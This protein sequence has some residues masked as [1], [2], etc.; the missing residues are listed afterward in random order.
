MLF[1]FGAIGGALASGAMGAFTSSL[2]SI[3]EQSANGR[4]IDWGAVALSAGVGFI[5]G[6]VESVVGKGLASA[7]AGSPVSQA[8][9]STVTSSFT[10]ANSVSANAI[11]TGLSR[12]SNNSSGSNNNN[13]STYRNRWTNRAYVR[14]QRRYGCRLPMRYRRNQGVR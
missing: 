4:E 13:N 11:Y 6:A 3:F 7:V 12:R 8:V 10:T 5:N 1:E 2:G 14:S 9:V